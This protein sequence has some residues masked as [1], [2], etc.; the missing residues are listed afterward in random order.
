MF[1]VSLDCLFLIAPSV[2]SN[3]Y[4]PVSL[5][6]LFLIAPS[7]F[8]NVYLPVSLDCPFLIAPSVFSNVYLSNHDVSLPYEICVVP[9][10]FIN[11]L[12]RFDFIDCLLSKFTICTF[13][14]YINICCI[15]LLEVK[16]LLVKEEFED[17]KGVIRIRI[18]KNRQ[19]NDQ[20]KTYRRT[21]NDLQNIPNIHIK[22]K[23][24]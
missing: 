21:N 5:D 19:H 15:R 23:I 22:L 2:F 11:I 14:S 18:S 6:C 13:T 3:V 4:L 16:R 20:K 1:P 24:E 8:S 17:T 7:V 9:F 10:F 12:F